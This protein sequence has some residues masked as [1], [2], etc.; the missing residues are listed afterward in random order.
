MISSMPW[1]LKSKQSR[2]IDG[3]GAPVDLMMILAAG[4]EISGTGKRRKIDDGFTAGSE[5]RRR[6]S[7][8][9]D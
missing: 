2:M 6:E 4:G 5:W 7:R 8:E 3:A 9:G 1:M